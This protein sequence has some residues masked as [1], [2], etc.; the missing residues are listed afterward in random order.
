MSPSQSLSLEA[1]ELPKVVREFGAEWGIVLGS[2]LGALVDEVDS[3]LALP[4]EEIA[5][6]PVST[7]AGHH[8]RWI[9]SAA[10]RVAER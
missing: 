8:P 7:V 6:L 9:E 4:Y 3:I 5:G 1:V 10:Q 2:G